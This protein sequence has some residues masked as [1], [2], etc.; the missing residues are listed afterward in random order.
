MATALVGRAPVPSFVQSFVRQQDELGPTTTNRK[1]A[2][3]IREKTNDCS[4]N[5]YYF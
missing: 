1:F 3:P 2:R 4:C 5:Y